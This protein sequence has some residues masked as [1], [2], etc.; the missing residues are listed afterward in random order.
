MLA[1]YSEHFRETY[2]EYKATKDPASLIVIKEPDQAMDFFHGFD[3]S[4][5]GEFKVQ[6]KNGWAM[7]SM[8][9]PTTVNEMYQ[10]ST[11]RS[12]N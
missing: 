3:E 5:Y 9:P 1:Q 11:S 7:K 6:V 8:K 2:R 12:Q 10:K 4:K